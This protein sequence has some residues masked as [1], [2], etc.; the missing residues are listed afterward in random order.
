MRKFL[1]TLTVLMLATGI[2]NL[3]AQTTEGG[4]KPSG[5]LW[6]YVFG[7]YAYKTHNDT[8]SRGGGN[9]QYKTPASLNA[10]NVAGTNNTMPTEISTNAFQLRRVYLG[11][12][13]QFEK[14][15]TATLV[16]ADEQNVDPSGKSAFY[17]KYANL[18]WSN[19]FKGTDLVIGQYSTASFATPFGTEPLWA[20]RSSERTILDLHNNDS[21]VDLGLSLQGSLWQA[22][23]SVKPTKVGYI[24]QVGNGNGA[25]NSTVLGT[26]ESDI[27]KKI[28]VNVFLTTLQQKL[29]L[30][31]YF[32]YNRTQLEPVRKG[33]STMKAYAAYTD[34][35]FRIG[36]EF[37]QQTSVNSD[38]YKVADAT[39]A[40][41]ATATNMTADGVQMGFSVF[42]S[43][44]IVK[45]KLNVFARYDMYNPDTKWSN[46]NKYSAVSSYLSGNLSTSTFYTQNFFNL[47][48]DWTPNSRFHIMPNVWYNGYSAM[49]NNVGLSDTGA[50]L[51]SRVKNDYDLV[52]RVTFYFLFNGSKK[53]SNNGMDN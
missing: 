5:N 18:K 30:G 6:G 42:G 43:A 39:G 27:F 36:A 23:D 45:S 48:L 24:L 35:M 50:A 53:V 4:F 9:V 7:D 25:G 33:V 44:A 38:V 11:Y 52:Y 41:P 46:S 20:Y 3:N 32:D 49:Q 29:T 10:N 16:L 21:S 1:V 28:R 51:S 31:L 15:L 40:I 47:G 2:A 34:P 37:F 13:Y 22:P 26:Q 19:I 12:D 8:L 14:N 17:L